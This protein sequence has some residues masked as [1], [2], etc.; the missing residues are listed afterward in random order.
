MI[1]MQIEIVNHGQNEICHGTGETNKEAFLEA[2]KGV[3]L[4]EGLEIIILSV[5]RG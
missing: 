1:K 3:V 4:S 5:E 2:I